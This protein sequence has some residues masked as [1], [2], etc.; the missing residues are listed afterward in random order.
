MT[1]LSAE[2][3]PLIDV[4]WG[5]GGQQGYLTSPSLTLLPTE[6]PVNDVLIIPPSLALCT[7]NPTS[8]V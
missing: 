7:A 3:H 1:V 8:G 6:L 4:S 2:R 5:H